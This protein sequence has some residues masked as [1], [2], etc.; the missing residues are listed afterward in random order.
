[1]VLAMSRPWKHPKTGVYYFRKGVPEHLRPLVGKWEVK[2]SLGTKVADEARELHST[3][4]AQVTQDW[5]RLQSTDASSAIPR[6]DERILTDQE[7][8]GLS[9]DLYREVMNRHGENPGLAH[10]WEQKL[11]K[12]QLALPARL[13]SEDF[14]APLKANWST[15]P[16]LMAGRILGEDVRDFMDRHAIN[17]EWRCRNKFYLAAAMALGQ[18]YRELIKRAEGDFRPDPDAVRFPASPLVVPQTSDW[19]PLYE[20]YRQ[21]VKPAAA[22]VKRQ[23]GVLKKFFGFLGHVDPRRVSEEDVR[24]WV[25][26]RLT[27]GNVAPQTVRDADLAHPKTLYIWA[28]SEK[29]LHHN[30][31]RDIKVR[32]PKQ[33]KLRDRE[34]TH[35]EAE[36]VLEASLLPPSARM[37]EEGAAARRWIPWLCAYSGARVNELTQL[38]ASDIF[39]EKVPDGRM[40][41]VMNITPEA[42]TT[43]NRAARKVSL[44]L[45]LIDQGFIRYVERRKGRHLFYLPERRRGGS[46]ANP[47]NKK[48]GE[49]LAAWVR[50]DVGITDPGIDPNHAWRHLF[51]SWLLAGKVPGQVIDRIDGHAPRTVGESY[52][53]AWPAVMLD[54]VMA[55]PPYLT[56]R[57]DI[58]SGGTAQE[59]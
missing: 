59:I 38:R 40:V 55:I 1:M 47:Q 26:H 54:A 48:V 51:R 14:V 3:V 33:L 2:I 46:D 13:R 36:R 49:R 28:V 41:W 58:R 32:V 24:R 42:G 23:L 53:S 9:G 5:L 31:F 57:M 4:A 20:E 25:K 45:D 19:Q 35:D 15:G 30:P 22:T 50:S 10:V 8:V 7:I 17:L 39:L 44:H 11:R 18:A 21:S 16:A 29:K 6:R 52:G 43:K 34:Y 12:L 37:T 56:K 27:E